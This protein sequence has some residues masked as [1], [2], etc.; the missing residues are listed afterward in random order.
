MVGKLALYRQATVAFDSTRL[1]IQRRAAFNVIYAEL[2][3]RW[4]AFRAA[5]NYRNSD[6]ALDALDRCGAAVPRTSGLTLQIFTP[7]RDGK[8]ILATLNALTDRKRTTQNLWMAAS[9]FLHF[10]HPGLFLIYYHAQIW[11]NV[12]NGRFRSDYRAFRG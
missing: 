11:N 6:Q 7:A 4:Q 8:L 12:Y 9:T 2:R 5:S 1:Q 10:Y 3:G